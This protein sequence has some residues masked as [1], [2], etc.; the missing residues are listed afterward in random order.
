MLYNE[1][2]D[3]VLLH[4]LSSDSVDGLHN[5]Q[6]MEQLQLDTCGMCKRPFTDYGGVMMDQNYFGLL[7]A[8]FKK[9]HDPTCGPGLTRS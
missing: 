3:Q 8:M 7:E 9:S 4:S 5:K 2:D 6:V 1:K